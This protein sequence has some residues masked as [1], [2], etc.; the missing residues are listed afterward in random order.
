MTTNRTSHP[1]T[2]H[3]AV[4]SRK[5]WSVSYTQRDV[6]TIREQ[7]EQEQAA[8]RRLLVLALL[9]VTAALVG[10]IILLSTSY[11]LY[12]RSVSQK[13]TLSDEN[14]AL[15]SQ[16]AVTNQQLNELQQKQASYDQTR[17][18]ARAKLQKI[19]PAALAPSSGGRE[20]SMLASML[21][22][23]PDHQIEVDRKPPDS[24][25]RNW[26]VKSGDITSTYALVGGFVDGKWIIYSNLISKSEKPDEPRAKSKEPRLR[27]KGPG[28]KIE[29]AGAK[30]DE[31]SGKSN[32]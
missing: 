30:S 11:G 14:S 3:P 31:S 8:R 7:I 9:I 5:E 23:L 26:R 22:G 15:K 1:A 32:E 29:E 19:L 2:S 28:V 21:Y 12:G 6:E 18:E 4:S 27:S 25:F 17:T 16:A 10:A 13:Q 20:A 24:L